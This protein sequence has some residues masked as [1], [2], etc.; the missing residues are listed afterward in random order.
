M[1]LIGVITA[2]MKYGGFSKCDYR[3]S[4]RRG[5]E[6]LGEL[7]NSLFIW[8]LVLVTGCAREA[9]AVFLTLSSDGW[10]VSGICQGSKQLTLYGH[11]QPLIFTDF[12][13]DPYQDFEILH[14]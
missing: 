10:L 11:R 3:S 7:W 14:I 13:I 8:V 5:N 6:G 2:V 1:L 9:C 4:A 12:L